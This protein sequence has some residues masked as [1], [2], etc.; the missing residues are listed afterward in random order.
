MHK[1]VIATNNSH[2]ISE[3]RSCFLQKGI[4]F[5]L[6]TIKEAGFVGEIIEDADSFEGNAYIKAKTLCDHTGMIAIADD[7]G[8]VVD[9]LGGAPGVYS[10]RY[11]GEGA[12]DM[13]NIE[14]LLHE[15]KDIPAD[16]KTARFVCAICVCR[17]DGERL[18]V[19]GSSE[20]IIIDELRGD[21]R[22]GYDPVFLYPPMNKTFAEMSSEEKNSVSHRGRAIESL[23][24]SIEFLQK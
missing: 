23:L 6:V 1:I 13:Q 12:T 7:S 21:G 15:L 17:P 11:A 4:E 20:G 24:E 22:F 10:A 14:K 9:A 16:E 8:L 5:E 3:F 19:S 2:K 18:F